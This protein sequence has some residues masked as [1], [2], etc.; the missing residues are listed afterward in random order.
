MEKNKPTRIFIVE[1]D[2]IYARILKKKL[3]TE[4]FEVQH[5]STGEQMISSWEDDPEIILLDYNLGKAMNGEKIL[6]FIRRISKSLPVIALTATNDE[7]KPTDIARATT[8]LKL[9]A[10]DFIVKDK[11]AFPNLLKTIR[12]VLETRILR[13]EM[14]KNKIRVKKY[15]QH[16]L[17]FI[18]SIA[19]VAMTLLWLFS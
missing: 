17:I 8:M 4:G 2:E 19:L 1:D 3:E 6:H 9:G 14:S 18:L 7:T 16:L 13:E 10:I 5:F 15:Q 11:E 12:Q